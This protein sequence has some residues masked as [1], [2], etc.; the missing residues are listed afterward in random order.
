MPA[1]TA[2][3]VEACS[4]PP[5]KNHRSLR[6]QR[7]QSDSAVARVFREEEDLKREKEL[8][9]KGSSSTL[10]RPSRPSSIATTQGSHSHHNT[11]VSGISARSKLFGYFPVIYIH[12]FFR[13][14]I[15]ALFISFRSAPILCRARSLC[16]EAWVTMKTT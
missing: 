15:I 4:P 14:L 10:P 2:N 16:L 8:A 11:L 5:E 6:H 7:Q 3:L 1:N 9:M 12:V 13:I